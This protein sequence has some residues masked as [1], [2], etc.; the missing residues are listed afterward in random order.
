M[1]NAKEIEVRGTVP[2]DWL[3]AQFEDTPEQAEQRT[4]DRAMMAT[5]LA[6]PSIGTRISYSGTYLVDNDHGGRTT[7]YPFILEGVEA[8]SELGVA[9]IVAGI[10]RLG[11]TVEFISTFDLDNEAGGTWP[12][13][14]RE[15]LAAEIESKAS[16]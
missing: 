13:N 4:K 14:Y 7:M 9:M 16:A 12:S 6:G 1:A 5:W 2:F 15:Q 8:V 3:N 10:E 11:G